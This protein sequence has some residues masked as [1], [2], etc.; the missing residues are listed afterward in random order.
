MTARIHC[1]AWRGSG[2]AAAARGR[3]TSRSVVGWLH[4]ETP[5]TQQA[6][7]AAA[8][9]ANNDDP[10]HGT[11]AL[12]ESGSAKHYFVV[13]EFC[14]GH[15]RHLPASPSTAAYLPIAPVAV[16][17]PLRTGLRPWHTPLALL[18][19]DGFMPSLAVHWIGAEH[20]QLA[21][22]HFGRSLGP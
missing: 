4:A 12:K 16:I 5:E 9:P 19:S 17:G 7:L 13:G 1:G 15:L 10:A 21:K 11:P 14:N 3:Q 8:L 2:M 20:C 22:F 18:A 6:R